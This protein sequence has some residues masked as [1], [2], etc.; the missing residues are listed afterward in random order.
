[1]STLNEIEE[2]IEKLPPVEFRELMRRLN[3]RD[4]EAWDREMEDDAKSGRLDALHE[5]L[6]K[7]NSGESEVALDSLLQEVSDDIAN[8]TN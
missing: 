6:E 1:M 5:R 8:Q 7:E 4:A 3:E 2:A